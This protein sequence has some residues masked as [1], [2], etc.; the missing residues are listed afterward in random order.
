MPALYLP[1]IVMLLALVLRGVAFEFRWIAKT[2]GLWDLAFTGGSTLAA[3][4]QGIILGAMIQGIKIENGQ[5]AGGTFDWAT[6]FALLCGVGTV[7]GYALLGATWLAMKTEGATRRIFAQA[8]ALSAHRRDRADG[9]GEPCNAVRRSAH[10]RALVLV[11]EHRLSFAG[12]A[13]HRRDR[14]L[15]LEMD[16]RQA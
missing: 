12:A 7:A 2:P 5:F 16:R 4:T 13:D 11:A 10:C 9:R 14:A 6:P 8:G 15:C 1:V 3:F